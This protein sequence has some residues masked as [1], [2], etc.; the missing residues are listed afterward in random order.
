MSGIEQRIACQHPGI[1]GYLFRLELNH[2]VSHGKKGLRLPANQDLSRGVPR[3]GGRRSTC[4][5]PSPPVCDH[6]QPTCSI[7]DG[8]EPISIAAQALQL[9]REGRHRCR[10]GRDPRGAPGVE[11]CSAFAGT[12]G[13]GA[14]R[15]ALLRVREW[16]TFEL[17]ITSVDRGSNASEDDESWT[18]MGMVS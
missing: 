11:L 12:P 1:Q 7:R 13:R 8:T 18:E 10:Q 6:L 3:A 17:G 14:C 5:E 2:L 15:G 4:P 9:R 16:P